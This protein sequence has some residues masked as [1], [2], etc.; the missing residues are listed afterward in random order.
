MGRFEPQPQL[1]RGDVSRTAGAADP[2][3][4]QPLRI[5]L[6]PSPPRLQ[7]RGDFRA[8]L[9]FRYSP[10]GRNRSRS[11][12]RIATQAQR[13]WRGRGDRNGLWNWISSQAVTAKPIP[14]R[15]SSNRNLRF[16]GV[17]AVQRT[18]FRASQYHRRRTPS[19]SKRDSRRDS[20]TQ[21]PTTSPQTRRV[22]GDVRV[23]RG[24]APGSGY[25]NL[26]ARTRRIESQESIEF[27]V[28][29]RIDARPV[30]SPAR[31]T[32]TRTVEFR[33]RNRIDLKLDRTAR[34]LSRSAR[35]RDPSP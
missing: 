33:P 19:G 7:P 24:I 27:A 14:I 1:L 9:V 28:S 22:F 3:R 6:A 2:Q 20:A 23:A 12:Q 32:A 21:R 8:S 34:T 26:L 35:G 13:V 29:H 4:I 16:S 10:W 17:G 11:R 30:V 18:H 31:R 5:V 15:G 25:R